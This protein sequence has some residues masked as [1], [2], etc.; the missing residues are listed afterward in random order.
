M[1]SIKDL[2]N[3]ISLEDMNMQ[4]LTHGNTDLAIKGRGGD[5]YLETKFQSSP[6][7]MLKEAIIIWVDKGKLQ[8]AID[9]AIS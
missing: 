4:F 7:N 6:E 2:I 1:A 3:E 5:K 8:Q 9:R